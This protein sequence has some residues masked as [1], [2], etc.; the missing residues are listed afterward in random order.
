MVKKIC[1]VCKKEFTVSNY[2]QYTAK[3]CSQKCKSEYQIGKASP[4]KGTK[5]PDMIGNKN[6]F[7]G[8]VL[9]GD[10]SF[11]WKG[12]KRTTYYGY[13]MIY[14]PNH[15]F[16]DAQGYIRQSHLIMEKKLKRY[17]TL[18]EV[19][20][21]INGIKNDDRPENLK[22]FANKSEHMKF[23]HPKNIRISEYNPNA[24]RN[25]LGQFV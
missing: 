9:K 10:K 5:R 14:S 12:G 8:K 24:K 21:H 20:H 22:L 4:T 19:I 18:E 2:K 11:S 7:F 3:F 6:Y 16:C 25:N 1:K 15:P 17:L 23:H 13:V